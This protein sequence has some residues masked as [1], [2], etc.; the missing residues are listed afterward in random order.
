MYKPK[1]KKK[2]EAALPIAGQ[3]SGAYVQD[4]RRMLQPEVRPQPPV[5]NPIKQ[6]YMRDQNIEDHFPMPESGDAFN[7]IKDLNVIKKSVV[8]NMEV[9]TEMNMQTIS[10]YEQTAKT[11]T[12]NGQYD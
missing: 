11:V 6:A 7:Q 3:F 8:K 1:P 9:Q 5:Y 10:Q 2:E 12:P 4:E